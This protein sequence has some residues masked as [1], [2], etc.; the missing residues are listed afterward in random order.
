MSGKL[1]KEVDPNTKILDTNNGTIF[2]YVKFHEHRIRLRRIFQGIEEQIGEY[3]T[4][5]LQVSN[6]VCQLC[7]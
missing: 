5:V 2:L 7:P 6:D 1:R 3:L 4:D